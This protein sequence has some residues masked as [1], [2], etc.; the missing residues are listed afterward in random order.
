[1]SPPS[2]ATRPH[3][4]VVGCGVVG[5]TTAVRLL[6]AGWS[7]E[8]WGA[9][10]PSETTSAVAAAIWYPYRVAPA[11]RVAEWGLRTYEVLV[12]LSDSE[13]GAQAGVRVLPGLVL[14]ETAPDAVLAAQLPPGTWTR[15]APDASPHGAAWSLRVPV[16]DMSVHLPW[17]VGEVV[18][19]GGRVLRRAVGALAEATTGSDGTSVR[20]V[21]N[22]TGLGARSLCG[23]DELV[24]VRGQVV[25]VRDPGLD[26]FVLD[27][28]IPDLPTYVIPR[29]RDC[30]LGGTAEVG[31]WDD[32]PD[33]AVGDAILAR[34]R[35]L[36]P[37]L[38]GAEVL[39]HRVGLRPGRSAVRL[40][41]ERPADFLP[42]V[43]LVHNYGHGGAG[44]TLGWG[45]SDEVVALL[46]AARASMA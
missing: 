29:G 38:R 46:G 25:R 20:A 21:V 27:D 1:M 23:D 2:S 15:G 4:V 13:R 33:A 32:R 30:I 35:A 36:E 3:A 8:V 28:R 34:C 41:I 44:V 19:R 10:L 9:R 18:A 42:G 45:C 11:D 14:G 24:P 16:I 26:A 17:L 31:E 5:L 37:R 12:A 43:P 22:C 6:D 39:E 7:V 40:E